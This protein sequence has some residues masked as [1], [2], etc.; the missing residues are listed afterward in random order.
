[1]FNNKVAIA[2]Q[3]IANNAANNNADPAPAHLAIPI[4]LRPLETNESNKKYYWRTHG[5]PFLL[6]FLFCAGVFGAVTAINKN[7]Q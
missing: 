3:A 6:F 4:E 7:Q 5:I 1:M 2:P